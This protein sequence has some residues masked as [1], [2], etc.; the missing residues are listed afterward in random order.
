MI[1]KIGLMGVAVVSIYSSSLSKVHYQWY[2]Q[3]ENL[4]LLN[5]DS[6]IKNSSGKNKNMQL[7]ACEVLNSELKVE[8]KAKLDEKLASIKLNEDG[9]LV[10]N[11]SVSDKQ[12]RRY[13]FNQCIKF[14]ND[15]KQ[16]QK[17]FDDYQGVKAAPVATKPQKS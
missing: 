12:K 15:D 11:N 8:L 10:S 13:M 9:T 1:K 3:A 2:A 16:M 14:A 17:C 4:R 6:C 5:Y 7:E